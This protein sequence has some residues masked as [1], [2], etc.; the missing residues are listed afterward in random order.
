MPRFDFEY[1]TLN[2]IKLPVIGK[3]IDLDPVPDRY[4]TAR[5]AIEEAFT[6]DAL[7]DTGP[8]KAVVLRVEKQNDG[9]VEPEGFLDFVYNLFKGDD[10]PANSGIKQMTQ[11]KA[12]IP[13]LHGHLP[14]PTGEGD[15]QS[16][17]YQD[18]YIIDMYPTFTSESDRIEFSKVKPGDIVIVDFLDKENLTDPVFIT[19]IAV[20]QHVPPM[21]GPAGATVFSNLPC[22]SPSGQ[23]VGN[24]MNGGTSSSSHAG[25]SADAL[26]SRSSN[27]SA[28]IF[29]DSQCQGSMG[30]AVQ[31]YLKS[32]GYACE[33]AVTL[34]SGMTSTKACRIMKHGSTIASWASDGKGSGA[35]A[36]KFGWLEE[37]VKKH[38]PELIVPILGG[39]GNNLKKK[40][41]SARLLSDRLRKISPNSKILWILPP[42]VS[43]V[44]K[45]KGMW[46]LSSKKVNGDPRYW[47]DPPGKSQATRLAKV[48]AVKDGITGLPNVSYVDCFAH[49]TKDYIENPGPKCDGVHVVKK[50]AIMLI[51]GMKKTSSPAPAGPATPDKAQKKPKHANKTSSPGS[52][53][54]DPKNPLSAQWQQTN[55]DLLKKIYEKELQKYES[56]ETA[57][58]FLL[59]RSKAFF[60]EAAAEI[61]PYLNRDWVSG[62]LLEDG[63]VKAMSVDTSVWQPVRNNELAAWLNFTSYPVFAMGKNPYGAT[64]QLDKKFVPGSETA[65]VPDN[66]PMGNKE[67]AAKL[68][69]AASYSMSAAAYVYA[70]GGEEQPNPATAAP[71]V[72]PCQPIQSYSN[73][74]GATGGTA[75]VG[76]EIDLGGTGR[77]FQQN[78]PRHL[79]NVDFSKY[80]QWMINKWGS[81]RGFSARWDKKSDE[82]RKKSMLSFAIAEVMERYW[83]QVLPDA[84][85]FIK[86]HLRP[87]SKNHC[88]GAAFDWEVRYNNGTKYL[89]NLYTWASSQHLINAKRIPGGGGGTYLNMNIPQ[90]NKYRAGR[91]AGITGIALSEQG[92]AAARSCPA[93]G[94]S[95]NTHYDYRGHGDHKLSNGRGFWIHLDIDADGKDDLKGSYKYK[96]WLKTY[97]PKGKLI[98][99]FISSWYKGTNMQPPDFKFPQMSNNVPNWNQMSGQ[100][101]FGSGNVS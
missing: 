5:V 44:T 93:P 34:S 27:A 91:P 31:K 32:L 89:P 12:R 68:I 2:N 26:R 11:I 23:I 69:K 6:P 21:T 96:L 7:E 20:Q 57:K 25:S 87:G 76:P 75:P 100:E 74:G 9:K 29:G 36:G 37:A 60:G 62:Y 83:R 47:V 92:K 13:E 85:V 77:P 41:K 49:I 3:A 8:Y 30:S 84:Q 48:K 80:P 10:K 99:D 51:N 73:A 38:K 66:N 16:D 22:A 64:I 19:P 90:S 17:E 94:S 24:A 50:G 67:E 43:I 81:G 14:M 45:K 15:P 33:G 95:T 46:S 78:P 53:A 42:P 56:A 88:C 55:K 54:N 52:G 97:H 58:K 82:I 61:D 28:I 63:H 40:T 101:P 18:H 59:E 79:S 65:S 35:G 4:E 70:T 72:P 39:N 71:K 98:V 86:S 1:G